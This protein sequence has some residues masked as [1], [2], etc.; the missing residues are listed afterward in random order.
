MLQL[1]IIKTIQVLIRLEKKCS[2]P[3]KYS[4]PEAKEEEINIL[5]K[6]MNPKKATGPLKITIANV[7]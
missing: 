3:K 4:F 2:N 6:R 5:T 1:G 7:T